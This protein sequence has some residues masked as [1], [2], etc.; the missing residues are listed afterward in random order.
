MH[1]TSKLLISWFN[2]TILS[3]SIQQQRRRSLSTILRCGRGAPLIVLTLIVPHMIPRRVIIIWCGE[4]WMIGARRRRGA[5]LGMYCGWAGQV[6]RSATRSMEG[7]PVYTKI[8]CCEG[9]HMFVFHS[10]ALNIT[11]SYSEY[12]PLS[13]TKA[14]SFLQ[15]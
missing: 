6:R 1:S 3:P 13:Y 12:Y 9:V 14:F 2:S 4:Q 15:W 8:L 10:S 5:R 7:G 11:S